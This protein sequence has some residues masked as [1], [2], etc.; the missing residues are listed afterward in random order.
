MYSPP[1]SPSNCSKSHGLCT[2]FIKVF[3]GGKFQKIRTA[4]PN[5]K[6]NARS[7]C[8][9]KFKRMGKNT[10]MAGLNEPSRAPCV[11]AGV[12]AGP[13]IWTGTGVIP[14]ILLR[15]PCGVCFSAFRRVRFCLNRV[16]SMGLCYFAVVPVGFG[17]KSEAT[18]KLKKAPWV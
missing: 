13:R 1:C 17:L 18:R 6:Q 9:F 12:Y 2:V 4:G 10:R 8:K 7:K 16:S 3:E 11:C 14:C 15:I 5:S